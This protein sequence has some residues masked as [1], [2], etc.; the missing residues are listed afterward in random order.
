MMEGVLMPSLIH[1]APLP[2]GRGSQHIPLWIIGLLAVLPSFLCSPAGAANSPASPSATS[3]SADDPRMPVDST[4]APWS[5]IAMVQLSTGSNWIQFCTGALIEPRVILVGAACLINPRTQRLAPASSLS[6]LFGYDR[7]TYKCALRVASY[8][9]G[10]GFDG[11]RT[12]QLE[13]NEWARLT[14]TGAPDA[15]ITP[16]PLAAAPP[17]P[18]TPLALPAFYQDRMHALLADPTCRVKRVASVDGTVAIVHTCTTARGAIGAP[19]LTQRDG[20]WE[21]VGVNAWIGS[22]GSEAIAPTASG[23]QVG[24]APKSVQPAR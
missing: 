6:V 18:D 5:A 20:R 9:V 10:T 12:D 1:M 22:D 11:H 19:L 4:R 13:G 7:G 3:L 14:L 23:T 15:S 2:G 24:P 17:A 8:Q 16:L 21:V